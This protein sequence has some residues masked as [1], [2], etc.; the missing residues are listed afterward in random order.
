MRRR[1]NLAPEPPK[2]KPISEAIG[3]FLTHASV[4]DGSLKGAQLILPDDTFEA[5]CEERGITVEPGQVLRVRL[6]CEML[7]RPESHLYAVDYDAEQEEEAD[8]ESVY[9]FTPAAYG[10][11][12]SPR[13]ESV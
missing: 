4:H 12:V 9:L 11:T 6:F 10:V 8:D 3:G 5:Y 1:K 7:V 13:K 2:P